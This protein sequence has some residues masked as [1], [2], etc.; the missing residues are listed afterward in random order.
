MDP[1]WDPGPVPSVLV[2]AN[3]FIGRDADIQG[4][5][6]GLETSRLILL[7]GPSGVGKTRLAR[8]L[9][10]RIGQR[11]PD[12]AHLVELADLTDPALVARPRRARWG[13]GSNRAGRST[14]AWRHSFGSAGCCS[15]STTASTCWSP[16][17]SWSTPS[18]RA[19]PS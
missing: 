13:S 1:L 2:A 17:R 15:S 19:A 5:A 11:Y 6:A 9:A 16:R 7:T 10:H 14:T 18:S 4:L 12:G 3:S 8:E